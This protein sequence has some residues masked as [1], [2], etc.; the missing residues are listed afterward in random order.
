MFHILVE[1]GFTYLCMANSDFGNRIPF[2][3]LEDIENRFT[4]TF[5]S[6]A[7]SALS[8]S[9][10]SEFK[11]ILRKQQVQKN[12]FFFFFLNKTFKGIFFKCI[13]K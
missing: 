10:N 4:Q 3:F 1:D 9:L 8:M 5:G 7:N 6:R 13:T 2:R 12:F 11:K